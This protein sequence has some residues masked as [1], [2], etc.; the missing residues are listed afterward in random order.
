MI[1]EGDR[2]KQVLVVGGGIGGI[3]AGLELASAASR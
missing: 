1:A 2:E 3:T